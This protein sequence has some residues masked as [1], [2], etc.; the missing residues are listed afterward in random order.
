MAL[1]QIRSIIN[2]LRQLDLAV[3]Q[4]ITEALTITDALLAV[5]RQIASSVRPAGIAG[6]PPAEQAASNAAVSALNTA[7]LAGPVEAA[8]VLRSVDALLAAQAQTARA[9]RTLALLDFALAHAA[10]DPLTGG[11]TPELALVD[12]A[13]DV[14]AQLHDLVRGLVDQVPSRLA[15]LGGDLPR[16]AAFGLV[17]TDKAKAAYTSLEHDAQRYAQARVVQRA[18]LGLDLVAG[19]ESLATLWRWCEASTGLD[20]EQ[21]S[22]YVGEPLARFVWH[23]SRYHAAV[24]VPAPNEARQIIARVSH[25][26]TG[27]LSDYATGYRPTPEE[28]A[29]FAEA[30]R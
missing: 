24:W 21:D 12:A 6:L 15:L 22:K 19:A 16:T 25:Q 30:T 9:E 1:H 17:A 27:G 29:A 23:A 10:S 20:V 3:P 8:A 2:G 28:T 14:F 7:A 26:A 11:T 5:H 18:L 4:P 13:D